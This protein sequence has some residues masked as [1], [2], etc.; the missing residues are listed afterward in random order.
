DPFLWNARMTTRTVELG[1]RAIPSDTKVI[2]NWTAANRDPQRFPRPDEFRPEENAPHNLVYGVG[3]HACPG[4]QLATLQLCET[5]GALLRSASAILLADRP[6]SR[7]SA[8]AGGFEHA[9]LVLGQAERRFR[10]AGGG[11]P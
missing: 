4:R 11:P 3:P 5:L 8:P 9:W 10:S 7:A 2:L 6:P 1:G